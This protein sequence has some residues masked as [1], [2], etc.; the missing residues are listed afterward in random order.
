ML[1]PRQKDVWNAARQHKAG[2]QSLGG[3]FLSCAGEVRLLEHCAE[4]GLMHKSVIPSGDIWELLA[5]LWVKYL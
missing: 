3:T 4:V 5:E 2:I 1:K